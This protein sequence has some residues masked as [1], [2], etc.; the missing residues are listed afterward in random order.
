M[1]KK[2]KREEGTKEGKNSRR[3]PQASKAGQQPGV[4]VT[5]SFH[6]SCYASVP[7]PAHSSWPQDPTYLWEPVT[8]NARWPPLQR[9]QKTE[10]E[11]PG[12]GHQGTSGR[13]HRRG[14]PPLIL[15]TWGQ[16]GLGQLAKEQEPKANLQDSCLSPLPPGLGAK[17]QTPQGAVS[18]IESV[19]YANSYLILQKRKR[20]SHRALIKLETNVSIKTYLFPADHKL[21][22][23]GTFHR[24]FSLVASTY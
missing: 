20:L 8:G 16:G 2:K 6:A 14:L 23:A 19:N 5:C 15:V 22:R 24:S 12:G 21:L 9:P 18:C 10:P 11:F 7:G 4:A 17:S 1:E 13:V 3:P